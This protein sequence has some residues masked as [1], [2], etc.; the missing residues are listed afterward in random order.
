MKHLLLIAV[1]FSFFGTIACERVDQAF[2]AVEKTKNLKK[3]FEKTA[4]E[5]KKE[6][7]DKAEAFGIKVKKNT[8]SS[9]G[10][11]GKDEKGSEQGKK[12]VKEE[13]GEDNRPEQKHEKQ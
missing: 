10:P 3:E 8:D 5:A 13:K 4:N 6:I 12:S 11:S 1:V 9:E 7:A 2:D